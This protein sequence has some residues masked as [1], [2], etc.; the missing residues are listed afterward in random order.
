[1]KLE[2]RLERGE[3]VICDRYLY[4]S[5]AYQGLEL[6][7]TWVRSLNALFPQ[8]DLLSCGS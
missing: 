7:E 5:L 2:P 3:D 1:M 8:P 4:S 6:P